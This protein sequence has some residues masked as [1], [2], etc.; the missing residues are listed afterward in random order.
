MIHSCNQKTS[1]IRVHDI[2]TRNGISQPNT[3]HM[4]I[5]TGTKMPKSRP[6]PGDCDVCSSLR[7]CNWSS[8]LNIL[9]TQTVTRKPLHISNFGELPSS[10][11]SKSIPLWLRRYMEVFPW[12][13]SGQC[14]QCH[15]QAKHIST[16]YVATCPFNSQQE[17][18]LQLK[19]TLRAECNSS[20]V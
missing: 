8:T 7:D 3:L 4:G 6:I 13:W 14:R 2:S 16:I 5:L 20:M 19:E 12:S 9:P 17:Q 10:C 18:T 11:N 15:Y 1:I